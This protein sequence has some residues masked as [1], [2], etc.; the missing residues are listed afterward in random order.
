MSSEML[1]K[2]NMPHKFNLSKFALY[3][4][5]FA[6]L[7]LNCLPILWMGVI[8]FRDY[9]DAF[10]PSLSFNVPLT[11][12]NTATYGLTTSFIRIFTTLV[13]SRFLLS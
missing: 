9:I 3:L 13:L 1:A 6:W 4:A 7:I 12:A 10:S 8:S 11:F 2:L 5:L